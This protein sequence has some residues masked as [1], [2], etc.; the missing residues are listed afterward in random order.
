MD[1]LNV[2]LEN[3]IRQ[4][5][6]AGI[7]AGVWNED[8]L[9]NLSFSTDSQFNSNLDFILKNNKQTKNINLKKFS[10]FLSHG[11][12][13]MYVHEKWLLPNGSQN[14]EKIQQDISFFHEILTE[15]LNHIWA[16]GETGFDLSNTVLEH[17]NCVHLS[18]SD[19]IEIQNRAFEECIYTA[20]KYN[21]PVILHLRAP[22]SL[23][24]QK[25]KW[26]KKEGV[27]NMMIHCYSGPSQELKTLTK[28]SIYCS[29]GG[30]PTW[31]KAVKN[32]ESFIKCDPLLRMLETDSPDLPPEIP[33]KGKLAINEPGNLKEIVKILAPHLNISEAELI[34]SSNKNTLKFLGI[35]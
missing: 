7:V 20:I 3:S 30:V 6:V 35:F 16:I 21:F 8:T 22:W 13:P 10:C 34:K 23:C 9:Q 29:F 15:N 5:V 28:L 14:K 32:R 12:H 26:A 19:I 18:K 33:G 11:L 24:I 17:K 31:Q 2:V 1:N 27:K 25:I 4:N